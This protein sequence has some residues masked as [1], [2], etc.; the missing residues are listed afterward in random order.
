[1]GEWSGLQAA[2]SGDSPEQAH[3][4]TS[5]EKILSARGAPSAFSHSIPP[6]P[7]ITKC[8]RQ[9]KSITTNAV[10]RFVP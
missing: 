3:R 10:P 9:N 8:Q 1:M 7:V 4:L 5:E 2:L 6:S